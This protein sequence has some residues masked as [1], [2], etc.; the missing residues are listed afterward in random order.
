MV[1]VFSTHVK[2][3]FV[4]SLA[5]TTGGGGGEQSVHPQATEVEMHFIFSLALEGLVNTI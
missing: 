1:W 2:L 4:S 3:K 5:R